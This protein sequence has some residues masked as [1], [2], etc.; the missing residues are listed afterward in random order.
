[1]G[2]GGAVTDICDDAQQAEAYV[3]LAALAS[4][5]RPGPGPGPVYIGG[6]ACCRSCEEPI[7]SARIEAVPGCCRCRE[8]EEE[9]EGG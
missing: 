6:V 2:K 9:A 7:C 1:M 5:P 8:C 4:V 3:L